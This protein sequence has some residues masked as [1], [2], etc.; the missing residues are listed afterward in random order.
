MSTGFKC[1]GGRHNHVVIWPRKQRWV[2]RGLIIEF[3]STLGFSIRAKFLKILRCGHFFAVRD[4]DNI[5]Y[6]ACG[7]LVFERVLRPF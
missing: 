7:L 5:M 6:S 3:V 4:F 1:Q 2:V